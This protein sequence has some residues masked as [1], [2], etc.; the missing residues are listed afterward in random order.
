MYACMYVC[1]IVCLLACYK[2]CRIDRKARL[3]FQRRMASGR[4]VRGFGQ[5]EKFKLAGECIGALRSVTHIP[6]GRKK[7]PC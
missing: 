2:R 4:G 7:D 5:K 6:Q 3:H 1:L